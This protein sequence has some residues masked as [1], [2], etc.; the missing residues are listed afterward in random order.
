VGDFLKNAFLRFAATIAG[1]VNIICIDR[2]TPSPV[3][4]CRV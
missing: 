2:R 4:K 1:Y 3:K